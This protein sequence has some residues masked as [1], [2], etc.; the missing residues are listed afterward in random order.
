M[1]SSR[2]ATLAGCSDSSTQKETKDI[3]PTGLNDK[4]DAAKENADNA[5]G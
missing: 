4:P 5:T 1:E 2:A 3:N